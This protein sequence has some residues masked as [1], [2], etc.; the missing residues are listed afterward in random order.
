MYGIE[1]DDR[2][3]VKIGDNEWYM[4]TVTYAKRSLRVVFDDNHKATIDPSNQIFVQ[5]LYPESKYQDTKYT[6][7]LSDRQAKQISIANKRIKPIAE[8]T[9]EPAVQ[10]KPLAKKVR[11]IGTEKELAFYENL[12][13]GVEFPED[14][15]NAA[16]LQQYARM[17][18]RKILRK[19]Y[20]KAPEP[21]V[22]YGSTNSR[23]VLAYYTR[24]GGQPTIQLGPKCFNAGPVKV[25]AILAHEICH[26]LEDHIMGKIDRVDNG[27]GK[28]W[29]SAMEQMGLDPI[30][31]EHNDLE[32]YWDIT[33][34]GRNETLTKQ[35][36]SARKS[37]E[38]KL[39]PLGE[40]PYTQAS[41]GIYV[42]WFN[43]HTGEWVTG[44]TI[45]AYKKR[46]GQIAVMNNASGN[47]FWW[48]GVQHLYHCAPRVA[49]AMQDPELEKRARSLYRNMNI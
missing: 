19:F 14:L 47:S 4:G 2:V 42:T 30:A 35:F 48:V 3:V 11:L 32:A 44:V 49:K 37:A 21:N 29:K 15:S 10:E 6:K 12:K 22:Y 46:K 23:S 27:H 24:K 36:A 41:S 17:V 45:G 40:L 25:V 9:E 7:P 38:S 43:S 8:E 33:K 18:V 39:V 34:Q 13:F 31:K 16:S 1:L 28:Y 5:K 26:Y 20:A